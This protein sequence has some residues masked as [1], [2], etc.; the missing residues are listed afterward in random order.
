MD[1]TF[2][3]NKKTQYLKILR[4]IFMMSAEGETRTPT[5]KPS[6]DPEPCVSTSSTTSA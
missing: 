3:S 1:E 2:S 4:F 5:K 6:Q